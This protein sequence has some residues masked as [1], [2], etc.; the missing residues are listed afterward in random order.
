MAGREWRVPVREKNE[1]VVLPSSFEELIISKGRE[2][3]PRGHRSFQPIRAK[4][5][6]TS[7]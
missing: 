5:Q 3:A 2:H 7:V 6:A 1:D 4:N